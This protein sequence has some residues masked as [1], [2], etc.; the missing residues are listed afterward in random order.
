[1]AVKYR[2]HSRLKQVGRMA[3]PLPIRLLYWL[4]LKREK[5][6]IKKDSE[7]IITSTYKQFNYYCPHCLFQTNDY[8]KFCPKCRR[9]RLVEI[10]IKD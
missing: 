4:K 2:K 8:N 9:G 5:E 6:D 1:M 3:L 7:R 10:K